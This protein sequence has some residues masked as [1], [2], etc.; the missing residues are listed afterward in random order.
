MNEKNRPPRSGSLA[1]GQIR[2]RSAQILRGRALRRG[3]S[4]H[5]SPF[6]IDPA[7]NLGGYRLIDAEGRVV[8]GLRHDATLDEIANFL[9]ERPLLS[10]TAGQQIESRAAPMLPRMRIRSARR[11]A[12]WG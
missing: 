5:S 6:R 12:M 8:L 11:L 10:A 3:Y 2:S 7:H 9:R 4:V 1:A